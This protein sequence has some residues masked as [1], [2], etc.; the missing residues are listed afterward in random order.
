MNQQ[1]L[2]FKIGEDENP[3]TVELTEKEGEVEAKIAD[4]EPEQQ[5]EVSPVEAEKPAEQA[6]GEDE[7]GQYSEK[8]KKRID[9]MTAKLRESQRREQAA[10][11]YAKN[12]QLQAQELQRRF[13]HTDG[14]RIG[15]A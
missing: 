11:E 6:A 10:L 14:E 2:E 3:A 13:L 1:E 12:V 7:L 9:K 15:E 5:V 4:P 8:V